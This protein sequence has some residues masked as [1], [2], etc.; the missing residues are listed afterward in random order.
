MK[1]MLLRTAIS[2]FC[3]IQVFKYPDS[4]C[5]HV[6]VDKVLLFLSRSGVAFD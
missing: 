4:N 2:L 3:V 6:S 5:G 1:L